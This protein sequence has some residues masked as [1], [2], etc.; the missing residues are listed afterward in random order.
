MVLRTF[1]TFLGLVALLSGCATSR[2]GLVRESGESV[3][4]VGEVPAALQA[5]PVG[6]VVVRSTFLPQTGTVVYVEGEDYR[7]DQ[8]A[9][10]L[11]RTPGS[12]LPDFR[13]NV[14][15]GA[16]NFDHSKYP[17]FGN[18]AFFAFVDYSHAPG[19]P[20]PVQADQTALLPRSRARLAQGGPFKIVAFGD[21]I[22]AGGDATSPGLI[23]WQRWAESLQRR[24]PQAQITAV[25]GATGGDSTVQGL[26]RLEDKVLKERPDLV[27]IGFGMNDHNRG[28]VP[29]LQF[30][31]NL[32][33]MIDRIRAATP[34]E[35]VLF[36]A[37]PPNP[38]WKF[39]SHHM[40]DYAAATV[41]V[42]AETGCAYADVFTNWQAIA[43]R[44]KPEDLL[45]NN[46][47][48]PN[49]FG[50]DVYYRVFLALGL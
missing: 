35:V 46:I 8:A 26:Q 17:G 50:H 1:G 49:D 5:V 20:W 25:N 39:G 15:Y 28:G 2:S 3:V 10:T 7:L 42:A 30:A 29:V 40:E 45:G 9:G 12:R 19:A 14:L 21:S 24:F 4:F 18:T 41:R 44:K 11:R 32:R 34:A 13:T 47:N 37:F 48:H 33:T 31:A 22:T 43:T 16:T 6:P 36:S 38:E 27:L 23:F